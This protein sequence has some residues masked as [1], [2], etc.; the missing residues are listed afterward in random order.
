MLCTAFSCN[1]FAASSQELTSSDCAQNRTPL[2]PPPAVFKIQS[3]EFHFEVWKGHHFIYDS[4]HFEKTFE[5]LPQVSYPYLIFLEEK[6]S[7][8]PLSYPLMVTFIHQKLR[9]FTAIHLGETKNSIEAK[10]RQVM[11]QRK[12]PEKF[13]LQVGCFAEDKDHFL[14]F[15]PLELPEVITP[16][17]LQ[18]CEIFKSVTSSLPLCVFLID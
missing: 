3:S 2:S 15:N 10:I 5:V 12:I 1:L 13:T 7:P 17:F 18:R 4:K 16:E 8:I 11:R 6:P 14:W 9:F